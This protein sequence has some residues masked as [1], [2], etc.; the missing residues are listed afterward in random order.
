DQQP[1]RGVGA[2]RGDD[3]RLSAAGR[4]SGRRH[5]LEA[6]WKD[7]VLTTFGLTIALVGILV[8]YVGLAPHGGVLATLDWHQIARHAHSLRGE[9][10]L[11]A[12]LL[13]IGGMAAK[14]GWAPV[15]NWLP[16]AHSEA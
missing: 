4:H 10:A 6:G 3:R 1:W 5:A 16:D 11:L 8:L 12:F 2:G 9:S 15:H 7:L 13:I 14:I